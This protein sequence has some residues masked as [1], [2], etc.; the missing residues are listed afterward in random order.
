MTIEAQSG[1]F[2]E[3]LKPGVFIYAKIHPIENVSQPLV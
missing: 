1:F 2:D 3:Q